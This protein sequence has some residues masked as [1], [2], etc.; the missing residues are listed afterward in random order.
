MHADLWEIPTQITGISH[1]RRGVWEQGCRYAIVDCSTYR[2]FYKF[3]TKNTIVPILMVIYIR[4]LLMYKNLCSAIVWNTTITSHTHR[5]EF[6]KCRIAK[7][8]FVASGLIL[9]TQKLV[10]RMEK[11]NIS[12]RLHGCLE[13]SFV[14]SCYFRTRR[15]IFLESRCFPEQWACPSNNT[16][17]C[18][19]RRATANATSYHYQW[20][21]YP[22]F[23]FPNCIH[24]LLGHIVIWKFRLR[25]QRRSALGA[26]MY[27]K[28][29]KKYG[30]TIFFLPL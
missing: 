26:L 9:T 22:C 25:A 2:T 27:L 7:Y 8:H 21:T 24:Y 3:A 11:R 18:L 5:C 29:R 16:E 4:R 15:W 1:R 13:T 28:P 17:T 19:Y 30:F 23:S 6:R 12:N 20:V 10:F 14:Y